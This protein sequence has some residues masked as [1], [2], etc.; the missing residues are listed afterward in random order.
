MFYFTSDRSFRDAALDLQIT[1][2]AYDN[3]YA[4]TQAHSNTQKLI[5]AG[6]GAGDTPPKKSGKYFFRANI[7]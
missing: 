6:D 4:V 2:L 3:R 7:V 1:I 5:G